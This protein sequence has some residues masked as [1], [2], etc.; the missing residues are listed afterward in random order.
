MPNVLLYI[1]SIPA[2]LLAGYYTFKHLDIIVIGRNGMEKVQ[3]FRHTILFT[4][5]T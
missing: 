3:N 2:I 4:I 1:H 5:P